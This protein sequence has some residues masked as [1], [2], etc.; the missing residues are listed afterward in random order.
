MFLRQ[1]RYLEKETKNLTKYENPLV[2]VECPHCKASTDAQGIGHFA[3]Q[4][5]KRKFLYEGPFFIICSKCKD[6]ITLHPSHGNYVAFCPVCGLR[7]N[8]KNEAAYPKST[9]RKCLECCADC[10]EP[11]SDCNCV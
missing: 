5:C 2:K 6:N 4:R 9:A 7:Y 8:L 3:C 10:S 11:F 1:K